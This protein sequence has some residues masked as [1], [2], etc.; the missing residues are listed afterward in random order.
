MEFGFFTAIELVANSAVKLDLPSHMKRLPVIHVSNTFQYVEQRKVFASAMSDL[1]ASIIP[2][3][4][5]NMY[6][7]RYRAMGRDENFSFSH[8][9]EMCFSS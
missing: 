7:L 3:G 8:I 9:E 1:P 5:E 2:I 6:L 4:G